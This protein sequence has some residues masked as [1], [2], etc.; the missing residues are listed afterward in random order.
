MRVCPLAVL[1]LGLRKRCPSLC[2]ALAAVLP[3][4]TC[5]VVQC[6][7][8]TPIAGHGYAKP[9]CEPDHQYQR[10]FV[11]LPTSGGF[12]LTRRRGTGVTAP[13]EI[14]EGKDA[15]LEDKERTRVPW[16]G[17]LLQPSLDELEQVLTRCDNVMS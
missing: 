7:T 6:G 5:L 12:R 3:L 10:C 14:E 9:R 4:S 11:R 13:I 15:E 2:V 16:D 8:A 1:R 17:L